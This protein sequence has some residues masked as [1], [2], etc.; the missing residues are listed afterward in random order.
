MALFQ[1][2]GNL[3]LEVNNL[4]SQGLTDDQIVNEL[5]VKGF[6]EAQIISEI[7]KMSTPS[8]LPPPESLGGNISSQPQMGAPDFSTP[9]PMDQN[10]GSPSSMGLGSQTTQ[11]GGPG[12]MAPDKLFN[13]FE[14][15]A[16]N[17][18]DEKWDDLITEVKKIIAWKEKVEEENKA[19]KKDIEKLKEDFATLH[20]GVLGKV[21]E[22]DKRMR[23]VGVELKSVGKVFKDV[24][25][26]FT[27]NVKE[28]RDITKSMKK[29]E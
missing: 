15:I 19:L 21:E 22:Y 20:Q 25:P 9:P 13:R 29:E 24:V 17:L 5:K 3:S 1:K 12:S 23:D 18:I 14:E 27:E 26:V 6:H 2:Q 28:L 8:D 10:I 16:E 11:N 4:R 7:N